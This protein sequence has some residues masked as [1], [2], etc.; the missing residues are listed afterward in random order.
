[1]NEIALTS[2]VIFLISL[3]FSI[4][5]K[6]GG[7]FYLLAILAL[8]PVTFYD[9]AGV[10]LFL[11]SLQGLSMAFVYSRKH[12]LID[13][14]LALVLVFVIAVFSFL[15]GFVSFGIP[16]IYLKITFAI[17]LLISAFLLFLN[18]NIKVKLGSFGVWHRKLSA[19]E[20][21]A[22]LLYLLTSVGL[23]GFL[24]GMIGISGGGLII[25][26]AIILGGMPIKIAMGTNTILIFV[27]SLMGFIG[28][29]ARGGIDWELCI[30]IGIFVLFG[31]QIGARLH[32]KM[33]EKFL[34]VGLAI[35]LVSASLW[36]II[37]II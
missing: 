22:H 23:V 8:L 31:S 11:I 14:N 35:L 21:D 32:A 25:P 30:I 24:A 17:F 27:S 3:V 19:G 5:G 1:M 28:H 9:A 29:V 18:K 20:Y 4:F 7:S 33:N 12:K 36:M 6:G 16:E 10:S 15:G 37:N 34:R 26:I 2:I 13:W